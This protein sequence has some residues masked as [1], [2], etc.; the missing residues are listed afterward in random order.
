[1]IS[2]IFEFR[3]NFY[4]LIPVNLDAYRKWFNLIFNR[5]GLG[6][7]IHMIVNE[8]IDKSMHVSVFVCAFDRFL[9]KLSV[10]LKFYFRFK[11]EFVSFGK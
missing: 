2:C 5:N 7:T 9:N 10:C 6:V 4:L 1:M 3:K 8:M 11:I